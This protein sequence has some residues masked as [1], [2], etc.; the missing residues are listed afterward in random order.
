MVDGTLKDAMPGATPEQFAKAKDNLQMVSDA[1]NMIGSIKSVGKAGELAMDQASRMARAKKMGFDTKKDWF[2]GTKANVDEFSKDALGSS[3]NAGSAKQGFF[4]ASDPTTASDYAKIAPDRA[5]LRYQEALKRGDMPLA[6]QLEDAAY[7]DYDKE[8]REAKYQLE[9]FNR[10]WSKDAIEGNLEDRKKGVEDWDNVF[11]GKHETLKL[12]SP[13]R[14]T[15]YTIARNKSLE[16]L[17]KAEEMASLDAQFSAKEGID[18]AA[19][20]VRKL[21]ELAKESDTLGANVMKTKLKMKNPLIHDFKG[22]DYRDTPYSEIMKKAKAKGHDGVIFKN[23]YDPG[24]QN[25]RVM[26]DIAA[27]FEPDQ[28]RSVNAAFDPKKANSKNIL[29]TAIGA[30]G[31]SQLLKD[32]DK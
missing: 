17:K 29:A 32:K 20:K 15:R 7:R 9:D 13:D 11:S 21:E 24:D 25:N 1:S 3:T 18:A 14:V 10:S 8:L 4:F 23:T 26:Q 12:D 27:V 19:S 22:A 2:H 28:I 31:L 5:S 16:S 30:V 6:S